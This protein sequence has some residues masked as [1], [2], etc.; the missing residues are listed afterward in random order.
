MAGIGRRLKTEKQK[1][2]QRRLWALDVASFRL[3]EKIKTNITE[4]DKES[5]E[6]SEFIELFRTRF[7][8]NSRD[9][10]DETRLYFGALSHIEELKDELEK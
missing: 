4:L 10:L 7:N 8:E 3:F 5:Y 2:V 1:K 9:L 6:G